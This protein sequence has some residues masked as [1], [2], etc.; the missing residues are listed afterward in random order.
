M[1]TPND[2]AAL[3][4]TV[5]RGLKEILAGL[6]EAYDRRAWAAMGYESWESYLAGEYGPFA[7]VAAEMVAETGR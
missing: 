2:L 3:E 6:C 7:A 5:T 1:T 4:R